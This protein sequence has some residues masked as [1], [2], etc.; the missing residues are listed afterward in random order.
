[1]R[2]YLFIVLF[3]ARLYPEII[4][5]S[6]SGSDEIGDGTLQNPFQTIQKG[7]DISN[8]GDTVLISSGTYYENLFLEKEIVLASYAIYD[9]LDSDW[10]NNDYIYSTIIL[11]LKA[12]IATRTKT[13]T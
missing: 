7:I 13:T 4:H 3:F 6:I 2:K 12:L 10:L 9:E 5:V 1:M 11:I 8:D